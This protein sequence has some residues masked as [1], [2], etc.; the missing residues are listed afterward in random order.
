MVLQVSH[1]GLGKVSLMLG[2]LDVF[3]HKVHRLLEFF[4]LLGEG[5]HL[6]YQQAPLLDSA[7]YP[8]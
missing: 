7:S 3:L 5:L 8:R 4:I 2:P 1:V 6:L